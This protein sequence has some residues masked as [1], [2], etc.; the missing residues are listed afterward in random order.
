MNQ[1]NLKFLHDRLKYL[2]FG[3]D[4]PL[5]QELTKQ[6]EAE[7][8]EFQLYTEAYFDDGYSRME[9]KLYFVRSV[10]T[11]RYFFNKYDVLLHYPDEQGKDKAQ[12]IFLEKSSRGFTFKETFNLLEGR[13]VYKQLIN[14]NKEEYWAWSQL[15]FEE[16]DLHGNFKFKRYNEHYGYDLEKALQTYPIVELQNEKLKEY[17]IEALQRGNAH[18]VTFRTGKKMERYLIQADPKSRL[19]ILC[20]QATRAAQRLAARQKTLGIEGQVVSEPDKAKE[21]PAEEDK[22]PIPVE[23]EVIGVPAEI[24]FPA[25]IAKPS[26]EPVPI[27]GRAL[28]SGQRR[29]KA[30][31]KIHVEAAPKISP[32]VLPQIEP[33]VDSK[34]LGRKR[35]LK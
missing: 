28:I 32:L 35:T 33:K 7:V 9:A 20:S 27:E 2:G 8:K 15:N 6:I 12:T 25:E 19:L 26:A 10:N 34:V 3:E 13:A 24:S 31:S 5:N 23:I 30:L 22:G 14:F 17:M 4:S 21:T 1:E 16:R 29:A 18:P 11:D